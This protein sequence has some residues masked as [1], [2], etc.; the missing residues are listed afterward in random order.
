MLET[1]EQI[2][3]RCTRDR[4][5]RAAWAQFRPQ[6][7]KAMFVRQARGRWRMMNPGELIQAGDMRRTLSG[8]WILAPKKHIGQPVSRPNMYRTSRPI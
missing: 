5:L 4:A 8:D 6:S 1:D 3:A 7:A 2:A